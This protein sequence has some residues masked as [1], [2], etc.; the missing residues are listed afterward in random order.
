MTG[1][2]KLARWLVGAWLAAP[3][4]TLAAAG[5]AAEVLARLR[6]HYDTITDFSA[7]LTVTTTSATGAA[8]TRAGV[9]YVR[10]PN[11]FRVEFKTPYEQTVIYDGRHMFVITPTSNQI[12]RYDDVAFASF[13]NVPAALDDLEAHYDGLV[14]AGGP[15]GEAELHFTA[16]RKSLFKEVVLW[17]AA[18]GRVVTR[19]D[20]RDGAGGVTSYRFSS[21]RFNVG[22]PAS[23][24]TCVIPAGVEVVDVGAAGL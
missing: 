23:G 24:F 14:A 6:A 18:D 21:Y 16:R 10:R 17:V 1:R 9:V 2:S 15:G 7:D 5:G 22:V 4:A 20:L 8:A 19:A 13:V 12:L 11:L 3:A